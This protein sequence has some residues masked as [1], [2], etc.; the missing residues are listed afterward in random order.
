[1]YFTFTADHLNVM[2]M[3]CADETADRWEHLV[4]GDDADDG[5]VI[6]C[7]FVSLPLLRS[8]ADDQDT[9]LG[10]IDDRFATTYGRG[11]EG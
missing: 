9:W 2:P 10:L 4:R 1:M 8:L 6:Y 7:R 5:L 11:A 3:C